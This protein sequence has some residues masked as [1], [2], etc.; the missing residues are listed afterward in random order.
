[1]LTHSPDL[2]SGPGWGG[3]VDLAHCCHCAPID[4][5]ALMMVTSVK[6]V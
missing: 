3:S 6:S 2:G 5:E 4:S 1:M